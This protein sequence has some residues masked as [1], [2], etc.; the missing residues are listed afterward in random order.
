MKDS[1]V[2][3]DIDQ[4]LKAGGA[5]QGAKPLAPKTDLPAVAEPVA[6]PPDAQAILGSVDA[7]LEKKGVSAANLPPP[8]DTSPAL[9]TTDAERATERSRPTGGPAPDSGFVSKLDEALKQRGIDPA[10]IEAARAQ[11]PPPTGAPPLVARPKPEPQ[12]QL[13][14]RLGAENKGPLLGAQEF[15]PQ[16]KPAPL[17]EADLTP[18]AGAPPL[19][20]PE[21][22]QSLPQAVVKGP[23]A[24]PKEKPAA[25]AKS[26]AKSDAE[27]EEKGVLDQLK[28]DAGRIGNILNPFKW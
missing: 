23:P 25:E 14:P 9:K 7:T 11:K 28:E 22:P 13:E 16:E 8:P 21:Q 20:Q 26:A 2:V 3:G 27:P 5:A 4:S 19:K 10:K 6:P 24:P 15:Q 17:K 1:T 12:I 18:E